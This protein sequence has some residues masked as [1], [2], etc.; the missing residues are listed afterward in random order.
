MRNW[1]LFIKPDP[2]EY[3]TVIFLKKAE[4]ILFVNKKLESYWLE[5]KV[6]DIIIK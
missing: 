5:N 6:K 2:L 4:I 1:I 3:K